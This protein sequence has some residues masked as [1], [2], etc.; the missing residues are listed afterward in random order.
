VSDARTPHPAPASREFA[1]P[2]STPRPADVQDAAEPSQ[3]LAEVWDLLDALPDAVA[4]PDMM[5]TTMEMAAAPAPSARTGAAAAAGTSWG[6]LA[7]A[8]VVLAALGV[9]VAAGR[10]TAPNPEAGILAHLPFV[11]HLD[12]LAE[13]GSVAFLEE[14][15]RREYPA[16][17]R[18]PPARSPADV[19]ADAR[20]FDDAV[21]ALRSQRDDGN[22]REVQAARRAQ[23]LALPERER[24]QL[25]KSVEAFLR[26]SSTD[27]RELM[28]VGRAL[29][30]PG[31]T[32]LLEAAR[33]WHLWIQFRDPADRRDVIDLGTA[34]RLEW[35]DRMTRFE[36]RM[37]EGRG[38]AMRQFYE[39][40]PRRR[41]QGPGGQEFGPP[42]QPRP[43]GQF[44]PPGMQPRPRGTNGPGN[45]PGGPPVTRDEPAAPA[46]TRTAPR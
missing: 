42:G 43:G 44:G 41:P 12:L 8:A 27:R 13:A 32:R 46:E 11:Q 18:P 40:D 17:R 37:M 5:A 45:G 29:A 34:D 35:L 33:L 1:S 36:A 16:P 15:V 28:A 39:R 14:L 4:S 10:A 20:E 9:G 21:A 22:S 19:Q 23:V 7:A 6:S 31:R 38:E 30:D 24:R 25:D 3:A 2:G 26:L